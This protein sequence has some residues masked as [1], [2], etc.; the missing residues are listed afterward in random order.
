[1]GERYEG[2]SGWRPW[3]P[4]SRD[5]QFRLVRLA[6]VILLFGGLLVL[7]L[8]VASIQT[9]QS[10]RQQRQQA[11]EA[12]AAERAE[13]E[14]QQSGHKKVKSATCLLTGVR[15]T[16]PSTTVARSLEL[17]V[18]LSVPSYAQEC[19]DTVTIDAPTFGLGKDTRETVSIVPPPKSEER[20]WL[21]DPEKAGRWNIAVETREDRDVLPVPVSV[22][23]PLGLSA[24]WAQIGAIAG[25]ASTIA[26]G[27]LGLL[28]KRE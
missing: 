28:L 7:L 15:T 24:T 16:E 3:R 23:T 8:S 2:R 1:V 19:E 17:I 26:L 27:A 6:F 21:L 25:V 11:Q 13:T 10:A 9:A 14:Q 20:R 18:D 12:I 5:T 4:P 22:T